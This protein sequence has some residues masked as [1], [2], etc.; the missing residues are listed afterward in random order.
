[1]IQSLIWMLNAQCARVCGSWFGYNLRLNGAWT[2]AHDDDEL[3]IN[4]EGLMVN[5]WWPTVGRW[6]MDDGPWLMLNTVWS[7]ATAWWFVASGY[8]QLGHSYHLMAHAECFLDDAWLMHGYP[9]IIYEKFENLFVNFV[10]V[11]CGGFSP[12]KAT[13]F[14]IKN[15]RKPKNHENES[16]T[17]QNMSATCLISSSST[18]ASNPDMKKTHGTKICGFLL[19][20]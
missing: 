12:G 15:Y 4:F 10:A 9:W 3:V 18:C 8:R 19:I 1:M 14:E 6:L 11:A 2:T 5:W 17:H 7:M 13:L 20:I 16:G